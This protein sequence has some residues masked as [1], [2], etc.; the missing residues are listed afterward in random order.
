MID[1][2]SKL[3]EASTARLRLIATD[4]VFS[5]DGTVTPL[6]KI[7]NLAK[8]YNALTFVD[9]CHATGFF[10]K[11]GRYFFL[12][13]E[14]FFKYKRKFSKYIQLEIFIEELKSIIINWEV[15]ISSIL[16]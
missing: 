7:I 8:K 1:L 12:Y 4:G 6:P 9:D 14:T 10:G 3:K 16:H 5:M 11:T 13:L 15:L 2:E